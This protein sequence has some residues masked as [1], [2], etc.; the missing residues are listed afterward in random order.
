MRRTGGDGDDTGEA[1]H[2]DRRRGV[3]GGAV[4]QLAVEVATPASRGP[5]HQERAGML[6]TRSDGDDAGEADHRDGGRGHR[7][8]AVAQIAERVTAP[9]SDGAVRNERAH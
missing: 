5:V 2:W 7:E 4:A 9:A 3:G 8:T 1:V 6:R